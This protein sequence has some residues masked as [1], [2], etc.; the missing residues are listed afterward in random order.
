MPLAEQLDPLR[1]RA[2]AGS[3]VAPV[4]RLAAA[5]LFSVTLCVLYVTVISPI[6]RSAKVVYA[7]PEMLPFVLSIIALVAVG[8]VLPRSLARPSAVVLWLVFLTVIVS[9]STIPFFTVRISHLRITSWDYL[10]F[11][12][13]QDLSFGL[14]TLAVRAARLPPIRPR[15]RL[16][17]HGFRMLIAVATLLA[18]GAVIAGFGLS[19]LN[20]A[21][22]ASPYEQRFAYAD[23]AV[24]NGPATY[25][26]FLCAFALVPLLM[27]VG[28]YFKKWS[29]V[30]LSVG[31]SVVA[32]G[33]TAFRLALLMPVLAAGI[34]YVIRWSPKKNPAVLAM[35]LCAVMTLGLAVR[36]VT[37]SPQAL[38][39]GTVRTIVTPATLT[40][41]FVDYY[42]FHPR[43]ELSYSVLAG[44]TS[45]PYDRVPPLVVG[46]A[47][48]D[49]ERMSANTQYMADGYANFGYLG[50]AGFSLLLGAVLVVFDRLSR[51]LPLELTAVTAAVFAS[52]LANGG[53]FTALGSLGF[54]AVLLIVA[55]APRLEVR[56]P[57][58]TPA[59]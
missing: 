12:I 40:P 18:L 44:V 22:I 33:I 6:Y 20:L 28:L 39:L 55:V 56:T 54:I 36:A 41:F 37:G 35:G 5:A 19:S 38:F 49:D 16:R 9:T 3:R 25:A 7:R 42:S 11:V 48:Y 15:A 57:D 58:T 46:R 59:I 53:L 47:Y 23:A 24:G 31:T 21:S 26:L 14:M 50:V 17:R 4:G 2:I 32:Y 8:L 13:V 29:L 34:F 27:G 43:H 45:S 10:R 30:A 52:N 1:P 51:G